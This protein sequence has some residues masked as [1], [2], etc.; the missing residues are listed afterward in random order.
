M[1]CENCCNVAKFRDL[2]KKRIEAVKSFTKPEDWKTGWDTPKFPYLFELGPCWKQMIQYFVDDFAAE[3]GFFI[4][5]MG[6]TSNAFGEDYA[7]FT[8]PDHDF[9]FSIVPSSEKQAATPT[10]AIII[11]FMIKDILTVALELEKR[12]ICFEEKPHAFEEDSPLFCASFRTP[13]GYK[14]RLWGIV[15]E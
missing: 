11:E 12:S 5:C 4:D 2:G 15:E 1:K 9:Y 7:M 6:F 13:N 10:D 14:V 3:A 8:S